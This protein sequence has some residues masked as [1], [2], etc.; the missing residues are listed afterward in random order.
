MMTH[1]AAALAAFLVL[2]LPGAAVAHSSVVS[3]SPPAGA[4]LTRAP[5]A[6]KV[7]FSEPIGRLG[8]MTMSRNGVGNLVRSVAIAPR[9][10]RTALISLKRPG[11]RN[12]A[13]TYRLTWRITGA[14]GHRVS[15][16]IVFRVRR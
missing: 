11:P 10:R 13:G 6:M 5:V 2:A 8:T 1:R 16:T 7:V 14:D 12:Q 15:G 4:T 9:D 3:S